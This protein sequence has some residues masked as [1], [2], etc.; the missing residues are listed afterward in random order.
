M[1]RYFY[2]WTP[3]VIVFGTVV[4]LTIP[5]LAVIALMLVSL[6]ALAAFAWTIVS[7]THTLMRAI[8]H[9][10]QGWD[11]ASPRTATALSP[12]N[13]VD[14]RTRAAPAGATLL[15]ANVRSE[16]DS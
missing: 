11:S 14:R 12:I 16:R 10:W 15:L 8:S 1:V 7:A 5:Y 9:R 13:S 4:L 3:F 2:A 6:V